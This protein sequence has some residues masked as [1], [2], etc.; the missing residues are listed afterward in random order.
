MSH[1]ALHWLATI[2]SHCGDAIDDSI[3]TKKIQS[4]VKKKPSKG[5]KKIKYNFVGTVRHINLYMNLLQ[6]PQDFGNTNRLVVVLV[7]REK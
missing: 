3:Q 4:S 1:K 2:T 5:H 7:Q 6:K